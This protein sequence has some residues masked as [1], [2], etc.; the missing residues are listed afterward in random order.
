VAVVIRRRIPLLAIKGLR[1]ETNEEDDEEGQH[2]QN[3]R[4]QIRYV[5]G[6]GVPIG[7]ITDRDEN[8]VGRSGGDEDRARDHRREGNNLARTSDAEDAEDDSEDNEDTQAA[9]VRP[10]D[11]RVKSVVW[12][13]VIAEDRSRTDNIGASN[14][15][16]QASRHNEQTSLLGKE[17]EDGEDDDVDDRSH[18]AIDCFVEVPLIGFQLQEGAN[19]DRGEPYGGEA[20]S[21]ELSEPAIP[22][23]GPNET[24]DGQ[25]ARDNNHNNQSPQG[26]ESVFA[27]P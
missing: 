2:G 17:V 22:K 7:P 11:F 16:E 3:S 1:G 15:A 23:D 24:M 21:I 6:R 27:H 25:Q 5:R 20:L 8:D 14:D 19:S 26:R 9:E 10:R 4:Q 13:N 18:A 12:V